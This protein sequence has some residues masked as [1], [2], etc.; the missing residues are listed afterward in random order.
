M[1]RPPLGHGACLSLVLPLGRCSDSHL[2][3]WPPTRVYTCAQGPRSPHPSPHMRVHVWPCGLPAGTCI[4]HVMP[5]S[6]GRLGTQGRL[7]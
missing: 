5:P 3:L 4:T 1:I 6:R 2:G 7:W